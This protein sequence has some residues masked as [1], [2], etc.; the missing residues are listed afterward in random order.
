MIPIHCVCNYDNTT[1]G[2]ECKDYYGILQDNKK[3][4]CAKTCGVC[5]EDGVDNCSKRPGGIN[6]CCP[7]QIAKTVH[8]NCGVRDQ[9]APCILKDPCY[10]G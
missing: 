6:M 4:C 1:E 9:K 5:V 2:D 3:A 7:G 8:K 10:Q